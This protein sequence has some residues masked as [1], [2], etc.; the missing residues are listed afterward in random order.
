MRYPATWLATALISAA[1]LFAAPAI[2]APDAPSG[3]AVPIG[4][5]LQPGNDEVWQRLVDLAGGAGARFVVLGT[6]SQDPVGSAA[7]AV[8]GL[9]KRGAVA[10]ALP[11]SPLL[12]GT[13]VAAAVKDPALIAQVRAARGVYFCGGAQDRIVDALMP[14][15]QPSPLLDAIWSVYRD[16]GVVAGTSAGAAIMSSVMFRDAPSVIAV[17]QGRWRDG[18]EVGRGLGFVGDRLFIDQHFLKRGRFGRMLPVMHAKGYALGLGIDENSAAVIHGDAV[19]VIGGKGALLVD[20]SAA[21]SDERLGAFNLTGIRLT[22]IDH[23]DRIDLKTLALTPSARKLRGQTLDPAIKDYKPYYT[24]RPF[25][26]DMFGD[27]VIANA[28]GFLMDSNQNDLRGLAFDAEPTAGDAKAS[29]GF[30]FRLYKGDGSKAWTSDEGGDDEYT[31][32]KLYLDITPVRIAQPFFTP[33]AASA[34]APSSAS[35][36]VGGTP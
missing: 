8:E 28:M 30:S 7:E 19:E 33:W 4:G 35:S 21:R 29:L 16:G 20:L 11:V 15:G 34:A 2:A 13:D 26:I 18:V 27:N 23:G 9:Q 1:A 6:G 25:Y 17:M 14:G 31:V 24:N 22:Y 36:P 5:A 3:T 32:E 10:Q 12:P